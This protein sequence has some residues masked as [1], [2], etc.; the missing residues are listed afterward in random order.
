[1]SDEKGTNDDLLD[2]G[3]LDA[4]DVD[5][6]PDG[7]ADRVLE[8]RREGV[9]SE[10]EVPRRSRGRRSSP[11]IKWAAV[12]VV[13]ACAAVLLFALR[14]GPSVPAAS[15]QVT[16]EQRTE[17]RLGGR[18]V[19]VAEAGAVLSWQ[20]DKSGA[21]RL[22][23]SAGDV[24]YRVDPGGAF[25]VATP[26]GHVRVTGT[27]FRVEVPSMKA[28]DALLGAAIGAALVVTVYEGKVL[29]AD[30]NGASSEARAGQKL[31]IGEGDGERSLAVVRAGG[32]QASDSAS[33]SGDEPWAKAPSSDAT[34]DEL[35][36]RDQAQRAEI[37]G[38][39]ARVGTLQRDLAAARKGS[40]DGPAA[41]EDDGRP[42]FDPSPA[43]LEEFAKRCQVRFDVPPVMGPEPF[44]L[45]ANVAGKYGLSEE[46]RTALNQV[47][48][49]LYGRWLA[50]VRKLYI[51]ATGDTQGVESL[52]VRAMAEEIENKSI[53]G[54]A[55]RI[56]IRIANERAGLVEPPA[57]L[58]ALSP[59]DRY[60]RAMGALGDEAERLLADQI[61]AKR[62]RDLREVK[63][64]WGTRWSMRG[65]GDESD[66]Q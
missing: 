25:V 14:R 45:P 66:P 44:S 38:M 62:S 15:G 52:S 27:C 10:P 12:V 61:G 3:D 33:S 43:M 8:A 58:A 55:T 34:R 2:R 63:D 19:A 60:Y 57:N 49:D 13:A 1:M 28:K 31:V 5:E 50:D 40:R 20:V 48:G 17:V 21:A 42:W 9:A 46:E 23:Q 11:P 26:E 39:Q 59:L 22:V 7:F 51:E 24:F 64:G 30:K 54:E 16:A 4:W 56:R 53:P 29:F 32:G 41:D 6:P 35:L 37:A 47:M 65:C 36:A 18:G